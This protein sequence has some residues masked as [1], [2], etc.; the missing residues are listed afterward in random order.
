MGTRKTSDSRFVRTWQIVF[1]LLRGRR[2]ARVG[3]LLEL[4]GVSRKTLYRDFDE[5]RDAG[6]PLENDLVNGE[7]R[8]WMAQ[9]ELPNLLITETQARGLE[10]IRRMLGPLEGTE[11]LAEFDDLL[12]I[13]GRPVRVM[14]LDEE[15]ARVR[16]VCRAVERALRERKRLRF[17]FTRIDDAEAHVRTVDPIGW[18]LIGTELYLWA[19]DE[20][21]EDKRHFLSAR[22]RDVEV[23]DEEALAFDEPKFTVADAIEGLPTFDVEVHLSP[24]AAA[25][26][27]ERPMCVGQKLRPVGNGDTALQGLVNGVIVAANWLQ[28]WGPEAHAVRPP[29]LVSLMRQRLARAAR[30]YGMRISSDDD[31]E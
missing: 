15:Q 20:D 4:C 23:L 1:Y 16:D 7:A 17:R 28:S 8:Y 5:M 10:I 24:V 19:L 14:P 29:Q 9:S 6:V 11:V 18:Q 26:L 22:M 25:H 31:G 21:R 2:K 3:E 27:G 13:L 12:K 30:R